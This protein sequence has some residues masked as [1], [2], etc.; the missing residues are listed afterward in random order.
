MEL[1]LCP[2]CHGW[3]SVRK[4]QCRA[5]GLMLETEFEEAYCYGE[6]PRCAIWMVA[7]ALGPGAVPSDMFP[8]QRARAGGFRQGHRYP[9]ADASA[10]VWSVSRSRR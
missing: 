4:K 9:S 8:G 10:L 1:N 2:H 6:A 5:C 3:L 7:V